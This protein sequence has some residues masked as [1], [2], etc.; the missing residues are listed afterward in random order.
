MRR[1]FCVL[2]LCRG[3]GCARA[4]YPG[5][6]ARVASSEAMSW[7]KE[8]ACSLS[9]LDSCSLRLSNYTTS[10]PNTNG[11][12][13]SDNQPTPSPSET[14]SS[15][16]SPSDI[17]DD[18]SNGLNQPIPSSSSTFAQTVSPSISPPPTP[19]PTTTTNFYDSIICYWQATVDWF[20]NLW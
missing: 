13:L 7:I 3:N 6:Y 10:T 2:L 19:Q 5:V 8:T 14:Y 4:G 1:H 17:N 20:Q 9:R 16:S 12:H 15:S 18:V 11:N